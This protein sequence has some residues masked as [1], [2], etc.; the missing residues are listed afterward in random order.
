LLRKGLKPVAAAAVE[1]TTPLLADLDSDTFTTRQAALQRL[2]ELGPRAEP[3]LRKA[4]ESNPSAEQR[5]QVE[6]LLAALARPG[7]VP[8]TH[9]LRELRAVAVL[10]RLGSPEAGRMLE[11]LAQGVKAARLTQEA[12]AALQQRR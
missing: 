1:A 11:E 8:T 10:E 9:E 12:Q 4:L 6:E 7:R 5:R 3:A 2:R